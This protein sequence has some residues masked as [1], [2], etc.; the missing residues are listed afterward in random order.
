MKNIIS[1]FKFD[2]KNVAKN[3]IVFVVVI[4]IAILPA[5]YSWFNIASNWDPYSATSGIPFAVCN[6]DKGYIYKS[7]TVDAGQ[8]IVDSLSSMTLKSCFFRHISSHIFI[9]KLL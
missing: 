2:L 8:Q 3:I 6:L 1:I 4:G 9:N 7:I 5:L